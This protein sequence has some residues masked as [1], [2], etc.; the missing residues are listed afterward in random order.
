MKEK[1][2]INITKQ[3]FDKEVFSSNLTKIKILVKKAI[4]YEFLSLKCGIIV[5]IIMDKQEF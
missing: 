4:F 1:T 2:A 3:S 5:L